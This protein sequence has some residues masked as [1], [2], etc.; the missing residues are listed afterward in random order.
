[1]DNNPLQSQNPAADPVL[2]GAPTAATPATPPIQ[3][4]PTVNKTDPSA[5]VPAA[6][7]SKKTMMMLIIIFL[8][9]GVLIAGG[10]LAYQMVSKKNPDLQPP[11]AIEGQANE[12]VSE[13]SNLEITEVDSEF[14]DIDKEITALDATPSAGTSKPVDK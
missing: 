3:T 13:S 7:G 9:V 4:L 11:S 5:P 10:F 12:M 14:M 1:M 2:G 6:G 8:V